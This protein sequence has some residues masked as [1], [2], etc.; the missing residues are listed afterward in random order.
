[1][2]AI[3]SRISKDR[4]NQKSIK[5]QKLLGEEFAQ[6]IS[7]PFLHY[8]DKGI[9]G[10]KGIDERPALNQLVTDIT[11][12][13]ITAL[14]VYNQ[15]RLERDEITWFTLQ[16]LLIEKEIDLYEDGV[17]VDLNDDNI[18]MLRNIKSI[19]NA[20]YRK[21][22]GKNI[23]KVLA[24]NASEGKAHGTLPIGYTKDQDNYIIIDEDKA[25][26]VKRIFKLSLE[27]TGAGA[28]CKILYDEGIPPTRGGDGIWKGVT[29]LDIIKNP[30]Y[31][32]ERHF[33]GEIYD[34]P[35]IV[36]KEYWH[37]VNQNLKN[38]VIYSGQSHKHKYLLDKGILG[39]AKCGKNY[40][41]KKRK[42][43]KYA[44]YRCA[45]RNTKIE[46][47]GNGQI[48]IDWLE[49][50]VWSR[51]FKGD[52]LLEL[53][54]N[55]L[56]NGNDINKINDLKKDRK[57]LENKID[58]LK[59]E[60]NNV[61][62]AFVKEIFDEATYKIE[63]ERITNEVEELQMNIYRI[64]EDL[65]QFEKSEQKLSKIESDIQEL[66][67]LKGEIGFNTK[68][69]LIHKYIKQ[70]HIHSFVSTATNIRTFQLMVSFHLPIM[71]EVY[72]GQK[73][74]MKHLPFFMDEKT[75]FDIVGGVEFSNTVHLPNGDERS[76]E[77]K[78]QEFKE[79]HKKMTGLNYK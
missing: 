48:P 35:A 51:F 11:N 72:R 26:L 38:N 62:T 42:N 25:A 71:P 47:C 77:E 56:N 6:K 17:K 68:K 9:S 61:A 3:Y 79:F 78:D 34:V 45:S 64:N 30:F 52:I 13:K 43:S 66:R 58:S 60:K 23:K 55:G 32:G 20:S 65:F 19:F 37:K 14:Y 16:A 73:N 54:K 33:G 57:K 53:L 2:L 15:D 10:G 46:W 31:K 41:G 21:R 67:K 70:I 24:R 7:S 36:T 44:Y 12:D 18:A 49:N 4:E 27:G 76:E 22:G 29:I 8:S 63:N 39:C 40:F 59:K 69:E 75:K 50:F 74:K 28:I 1:M 5:E